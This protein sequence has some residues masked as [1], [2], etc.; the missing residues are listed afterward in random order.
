MNEKV[1][2]LYL[3]FGSTIDLK[4]SFFFQII[5]EATWLIMMPRGLSQSYQ[6]LVLLENLFEQNLF[7]LFD[8]NQRRM[9]RYSLRLRWRPLTS[10][11]LRNDG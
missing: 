2:C 4:R 5:K 11:R 7:V 1:V 8:C 3:P 9:A 10:L 6:D